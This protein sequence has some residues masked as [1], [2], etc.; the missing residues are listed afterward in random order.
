LR[1]YALWTGSTDDFCKAY[2]VFK[3]TLWAWRRTYVKE[4][5]ACGRENVLPSKMP[6]YSPDQR[7][8][9]VEAFAKSGQSVKDFSRLWGLEKGNC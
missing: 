3:G 5:H 6:V 1:A 9:A 4:E 7:R 2:K 8:Q